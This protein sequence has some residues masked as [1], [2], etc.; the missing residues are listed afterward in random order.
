MVSMAIAYLPGCLDDEYQAI[1]KVF[2][3]S[4]CPR[5]LGTEN[6]VRAK[7]GRHIR[8]GTLPPQRPAKKNK[9]GLGDAVARD[10]FSRHRQQGED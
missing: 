1:S 6:E 4:G 3:Q 8:D 2:R 5:R 7:I 10:A 9:R